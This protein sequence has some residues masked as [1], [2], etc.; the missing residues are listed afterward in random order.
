[1]HCTSNCTYK[2][3]QISDSLSVIIPLSYP[4]FLE[5]FC[6]NGSMEICHLLLCFSVNFQIISIGYTNLV[7]LRM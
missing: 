3:L 5:R 2:Q 1:M 7:S 6:Y 4:A